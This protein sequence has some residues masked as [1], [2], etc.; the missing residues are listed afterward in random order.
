[1]IFNQAQDT[2]TNSGMT[3]A[4]LTAFNNKFLK[5]EGKQKGTMVK[6]MMQDVMANN[7]NASDSHTVDVYLNNVKITDTSSIQT[8]KTYTV[9]MQYGSSNATDHTRITQINVTG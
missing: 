7:A 3:E 5:Y 6:S 1:M 2:V 4:E 8:K 9:T